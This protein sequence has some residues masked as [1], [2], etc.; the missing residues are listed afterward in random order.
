MRDASIQ[1]APHLPDDLRPMNMPSQAEHGRGT[2][3]S[4]SGAS[5]MQCRVPQ[6]RVRTLD[7]NLGLTLGRGGQTAKAADRSVRATPG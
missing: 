3:G 1:S 2:L 5:G 7:E 4:P 6:V